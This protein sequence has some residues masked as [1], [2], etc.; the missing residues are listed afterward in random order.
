[1][2]TSTKVRARAVLGGAF[3]KLLGGDIPVD[4]KTLEELGALL[5]KHIVR[6]ASRDLAKQ[7]KSPIAK[8]GNACSGEREPEGLPTSVSFLKSFS[9]RIKGKATIEILSTWPFLRQATEG[10]EPYKM[11]WL[12]QE[13]GVRAV[14][15]V[16]PDGT[17]LVRTTP[18]TTADAWCHPGFARHTFINR[19]VKK[20]R[21]EMAQI[22]LERH[23]A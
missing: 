13:Q 22:I 20:A 2:P 5:V 21:K 10:R 8:T 23:L 16:Q 6:E 11:T 7:G 12:T 14:P 9:Y 18:L 1:M 19:A 15:M 4:R 3:G 17:V